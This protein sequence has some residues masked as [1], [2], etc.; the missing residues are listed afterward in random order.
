MLSLLLN[1][2]NP[3]VIPLKLI[4]LKL[5]KCTI[6]MKNTATANITWSYKR[7]L[8]LTLKP[9]KAPLEID[10]VLENSAKIL[11]L[12]WIIISCVT[13]TITRR[14]RVGSFS[15]LFSLLRTKALLILSAGTS[16]KTKK[17]AHPIVKFQSVRNTQFLLTVFYKEKTRSKRKFSK[18]V[19]F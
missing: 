16:L 6:S 13:L 18:M 3:L 1:K 14:V 8:L 17:S 15:T 9:I 12:A 11:L 7:F 4:T 5:L 19:L 10:T 2:H